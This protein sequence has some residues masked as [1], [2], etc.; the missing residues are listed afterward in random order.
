MQPGYRG[1]LLKAGADVGI[2]LPRVYPETLVREFV[3]PAEIAVAVRKLHYNL[4]QPK[5][6]R[7]SAIFIMARENIPTNSAVEEALL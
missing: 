7:A 3:A 1:R 2:R 4:L 5:S 6:F